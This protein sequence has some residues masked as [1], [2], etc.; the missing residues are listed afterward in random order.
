M[1]PITKTDLSRLSGVSQ[2]AVSKAVRQGKLPVL[3]D[4]TIDADAPECIA[5]ISAR[6]D[7][8]KS[9]QKKTKKKKAARVAPKPPQ[10]MPDVF[11]S[12]GEIGVATRKLAMELQRLSEQTQNMMLKNAQLE[13]KLVSRDV[14]ESRIW[15][16][17]ETFLARL[18]SDGV[19]TIV[20]KIMPMARNGETRQNCEIAVRKEISSLV[21]SFK[22]A[23]TRSKKVCQSD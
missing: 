19:K 9:P 22:A 12:D 17:T 15:N 2:A 18:L 8:K 13:G 5:Y 7:R 21:K 6:D 16:P 1:R 20:A 10:P 23:M 11:D 3:P 4:G 14:F